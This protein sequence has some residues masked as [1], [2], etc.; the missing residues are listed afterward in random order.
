MTHNYATITCNDYIESILLHIMWNI[1]IFN[2]VW[3]SIF[4]RLNYE[5][6]DRFVAPPPLQALATVFGL[7]MPR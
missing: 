7:G 4:T 6:Q 1:L 3:H 5:Y 2:N